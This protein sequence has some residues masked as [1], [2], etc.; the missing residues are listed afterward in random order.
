M[1]EAA[2][3]ESEKEA[4]VV[5]AGAAE[6]ARDKAFLSNTSWDD[7]ALRPELKQS[8]LRKNWPKPSKIQASS[9]P[10]VLKSE[11]SQVHL[12]GQAM[13]GSGKTG[14]FAIAALQKLDTEVQAPQAIILAPTRL[15]AD[16]VSRRSRQRGTCCAGTRRAGVLGQGSVAEPSQ[17]SLFSACVLSTLL[18]TPH[19]SLAACPPNP[20]SLLPLSLPLSL[21]SSGRCAMWSRSW[22]CL[23]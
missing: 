17:G 23:A 6:V 5:V 3:T 7:L 19:S 14:A 10:Y 2:L 15:L 18:T 12:I 13:G 8:V 1:R 22:P 20:L 11:E 4:T 9:L 16:Q 21:F